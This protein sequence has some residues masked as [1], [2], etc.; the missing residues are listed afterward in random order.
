MSNTMGILVGKGGYSDSRTIKPLKNFIMKF[1]QD[2]IDRHKKSYSAIGGYRKL[3]KVSIKA[4]M[5][6]FDKFFQIASSEQKNQEK[7]KEQIKDIL[8]AKA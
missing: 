6:S 5:S 1:V 3:K 7:F 2:S 4:L 8:R